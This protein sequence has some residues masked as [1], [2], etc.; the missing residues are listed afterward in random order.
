MLLTPSN[1]L[2]IITLNL[3]QTRLLRHN[4]ALI[5]LRRRSRSTG[6]GSVLG[7]LVFGL[8]LAVFLVVFAGSGG[9]VLVVV[10]LFDA[11]FVIDFFGL[12]GFALFGFGCCW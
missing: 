10:D 2:L 1:L 5:L 9:L 7:V 6:L 8:L 4:P 11:F 3:I 12:G